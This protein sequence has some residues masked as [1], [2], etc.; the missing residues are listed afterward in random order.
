[1]INLNGG[2]A[3]LI[4]GF[5]GFR[6]QL[7]GHVALGLAHHGMAGGTC[8][9]HDIQEAATEKKGTRSQYRLQRP[10][11]F[12]SGLTSSLSPLLNIPPVPN[13]ATDLGRS[14]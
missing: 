4:R 12:P 9:F 14:F 10:C 1:M 5:P 8:L 13:N 11:K 7:L 3:F 6:P 2:K